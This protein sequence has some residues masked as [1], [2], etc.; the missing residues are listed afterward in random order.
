MDD[1]FTFQF[2]AYSPDTIPMTRLASYLGTLADLMGEK[3]HVTFKE[4]RKGSTMILAKVDTDYVEPVSRHLTLASTAEAPDALRN[5]FEAMNKNLQQD[6]ASGV[7]RLGKA[8][9]LE[10]PGA[11]EKSSNIGPVKEFTEIDG[12][13]TSVGGKDKSK[14]ILLLDHDTG[15]QCRLQTN[16]ISLAKEMGKYLFESVTV[17][18]KGTWHR[19]N[20]RWEM[21]VLK[22]EEF[23]PFDS[24]N[25]SETI[26]TL[27]A[28]NGNGWKKMEDPLAEAKLIRG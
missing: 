8:E 23:E 18:G 19:V 2:D 17:K 14:N 26:N 11:N 24:Q 9:V 3:D 1:I 10:F 6:R 7:I 15:N 25:L 22:V 13:I 21:S 27:R 5:S 28:L 20:G 4:L 12:T 16:D